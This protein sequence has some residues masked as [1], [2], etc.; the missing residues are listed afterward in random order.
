M[1]HLE[2]WFSSGFGS[3]RLTVELSDLRGL[4]QHNDSTSIT[5][6]NNSLLRYRLI[7]KRNGKIKPRSFGNLKMCICLA[8]LNWFHPLKSFVILDFNYCMKT[9]LLLFPMKIVFILEWLSHRGTP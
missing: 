6:I 5:L 1:W 7:K 4:F 9:K 2:T 3:I 8:R